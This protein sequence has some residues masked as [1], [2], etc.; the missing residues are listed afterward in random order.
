MWF[1]WFIGFESNRMRIATWTW[2]LSLGLNIHG[3]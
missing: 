2:L 3:S 1:S